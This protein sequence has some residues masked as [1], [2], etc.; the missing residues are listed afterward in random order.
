[1][2]GFKASLS[3]KQID[4]VTEYVLK[5]SGNKVNANKAA[6]GKAV[7]EGAGGCFACHTKAGTG[8]IAMGS[9][10]L[11]DKVWTVADVQG[12]KTLADKKAA[13][14]AVISKGISRDMP[15]WQGRLS[16]ADIKMLTFYV[17]QIGG[18]K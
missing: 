17:H 13:V 16:D 15:A 11:T 1:M 12:A 9:A 10:N 2:P 7:F 6:K 4:N 3:T 5:L 8:Q 18:G 14:K